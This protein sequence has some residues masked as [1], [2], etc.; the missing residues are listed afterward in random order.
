MQVTPSGPGVRLGEIATPL[1]QR[2]INNSL[3][4]LGSLWFPGLWWL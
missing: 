4:V 2:V 3:P 1:S